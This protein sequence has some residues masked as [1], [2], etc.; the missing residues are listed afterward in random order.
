MGSSLNVRMA[1]RGA[2]AGVAGSSR[3]KKKQ[4]T[5]QL[6]LH[7]NQIAKDGSLTSYISTVV[8]PKFYGKYS[9]REISSALDL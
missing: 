2:E 8:T 9:K 1:K 4:C 3:S 7:L 5:S 6:N